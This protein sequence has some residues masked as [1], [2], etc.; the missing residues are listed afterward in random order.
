MRPPPLAKLMTVAAVIAAVAG[1]GCRKKNAAPTGADTKPAATQVAAGPLKQD[2]NLPGEWRPVSINL[3]GEMLPSPSRMI[4]TV[5]ITGAGLWHFNYA[6]D[7]AGVL[8]TDY[9]AKYLADGHIE[10]H[11]RGAAGQTVLTGSFKL[12][13]A[14]KFV[15]VISRM[16][17]PANPAMTKNFEYW[18][19][20][21]RNK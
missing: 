15:L 12:E 10:L 16:K 2:P 4:S 9:D 21:E 7:A 11:P 1:A 3:L 14:N 5:Q 13:T 20:C 17:D 18:V 6:K 8:A 19:E